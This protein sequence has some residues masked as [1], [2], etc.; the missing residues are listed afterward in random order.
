[1]HVARF[2]FNRINVAGHL[3]DH[4][5]IMLHNFRLVAC[6]R[7]YLLHGDRYLGRGGRILRG[8]ELENMGGIRQLAAGLPDVLHERPH[9]SGHLV[10]TI[11]QLPDFI[12]LSDAGAYGQIA[13]PELQHS[14][15]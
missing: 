12:A 2:L 10:E 8:A 6:P 14:G 4:N 7:R 3:L 15:L 11:C 5:S 1:M 13:L 9:L